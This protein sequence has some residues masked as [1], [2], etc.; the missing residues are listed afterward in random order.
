MKD[1]VFEHAIEALSNAVGLFSPAAAALA[2][3]ISRALRASGVMDDLAIQTRRADFCERTARDLAG[4]FAPEVLDRCTRDTI[5]RIRG[6]NVEL[7]GNWLDA[8]GIIQDDDS[9]LREV[10]IR[11]IDM[12]ASASLG[13]LSKVERRA[14]WLTYEVSAN[15]DSLLGLA[16]DWDTRKL[17][18]F[19][20]LTSW[21]EGMPECESIIRGRVV[22]ELESVVLQQ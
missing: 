9:L 3:D 16:Q 6:S 15:A 4:L 11:D 18:S 2:I 10:A 5:R 22:A 20:P 19:D 12:R 1:R 13:T 21:T 8:A 7:A 17:S 14:L